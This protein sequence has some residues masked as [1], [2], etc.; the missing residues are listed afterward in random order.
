MKEVIG[1]ITADCLNRIVC[2][3]TRLSLPNYWVVRRKG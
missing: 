2:C 3:S 1:S